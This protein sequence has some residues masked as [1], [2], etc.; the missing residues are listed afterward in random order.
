MEHSP[1]FLCALRCDQEHETQLEK[2]QLE[3]KVRP[4]PR[5]SKQLNAP[6][7]VSSDSLHKL[8]AVRAER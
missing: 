1:P 3:V 8:A 2:E 5:T 4:R 6:F 7:T